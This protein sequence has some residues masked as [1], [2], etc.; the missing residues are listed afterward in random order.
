M[1][2]SS[3][4]RHLAERRCDGSV[5]P[6]IHPSPGEGDLPGMRSERQRPRE[7]QHVQVARDRT[8]VGSPGAG[9]GIEHAE[10]DQY[11]GVSSVSDIGKL[12][13]T[14]AEAAPGV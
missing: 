7:E 14:V 9:L 5:V 10:E 2:S 3:L 11:R 6:V 12:R 13:H 1:C 8:A 4:K